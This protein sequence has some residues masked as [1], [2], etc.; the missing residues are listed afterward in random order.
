VLDAAGISE[1]LLRAGLQEGDTVMIGS[2][3]LLWS[4]TERFS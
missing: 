3:E 1:A 2:Q 4:D